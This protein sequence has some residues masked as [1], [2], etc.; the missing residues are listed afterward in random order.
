MRFVSYQNDLGVRVGLVSNEQVLDITD[1]V[2]SIMDLIEQPK[3]L[4]QLNDLKENSSDA[5]WESLNGLKLLCPIHEPRRNI[6]CVGWNYM[7]HYNEGVGKRKE[8][9]RELPTV[10]TFFTK[11]T[12]AAIGPYSE[13]PYDPRISDNYD[14]EGELAVVIGKRGRNIEESEAMTYVFGYMVANDISARDL[15]RLH[16]GQWFKG[17]ALDYTAPMG[18][19][20]IT[21]DEIPNPQQLDIQL[22][23][24]GELMQ[25]SNTRYMIFSI[26]RL[27]A[28]LS[29]GLTLLPGDILLT[30]TPEGVG[31]TRTPPVFLRDGD[32]VKVTVQNVGT[33]INKMTVVSG[34]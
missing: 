7:E 28:E 15:Q 10:P 4:P 17:K 16:G 21:A 24:N 20:L 27:I 30:G 8:L 31:W 6:F 2:G 9:E 1:D 3:L 34:R 19:G 11:A 14:Y 32:E 12:C 18:P 29:R 22:Y 5:V 25:S 23:L 33:I 26:P 13:I